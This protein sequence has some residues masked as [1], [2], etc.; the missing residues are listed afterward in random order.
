[1]VPLLISLTLS[2]AW[3]AQV[4]ADRAPP[5]PRWL[6][7]VALVILTVAGLAL[8]AAW[9]EGPVALEAAYTR[10]LVPGLLTIAVAASLPAVLARGSAALAARL[11][12]GAALMGAISARMDARVL[13]LVLADDP[14]ARQWFAER[15]A[16]VWPQRGW[17]DALGGALALAAVV[18]L[19][20]R[21]WALAAVGGVVLAGSAAAVGLTVSWRQLWDPATVARVTDVAL[22][23]IEVGVPRARID[24]ADIASG[25]VLAAG[26]GL[27]LRGVSLDG[28]EGVVV[29]L[30]GT[31]GLPASLG[32][33]G[34]R[35]VPVL[36]DATGAEAVVFG[37]AR[38]VWMEAGDSV[39]ALGS[40]G[41]APARLGVDRGTL[42]L[43]AAPDWQVGDIAALC[44]VGGCVITPPSA[45]PTALLRGETGAS[46]P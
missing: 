45:E 38:Q 17:V 36:Q 6:G 7:G 40:I 25:R 18:A 39:R 32:W 24:G 44:A 16:A 30:P 29:R 46:W 33:V 10:A 13:Q 2:V 9:G 26:A 28:V 43:H 4:H 27:R 3:I 31:E 15:I 14:A 22:P 35:A 37:G 41:V 11:L 5:G 23:V 20:P 12:V 8:Q 34:L 21:R 19:R 1:M 42:A